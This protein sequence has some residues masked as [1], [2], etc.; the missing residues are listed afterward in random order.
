MIV[1]KKQKI[2]SCGKVASTLRGG[3]SSLK[4][5]LEEEFSKPRNVCRKV[6]IP[7]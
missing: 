2:H 5:R 6:Q 1:F 4:N 3:R 7:S